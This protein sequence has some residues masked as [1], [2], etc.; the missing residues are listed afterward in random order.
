MVPRVRRRQEQRV[1]AEALAGA[2]AIETT[3]ADTLDPRTISEWWHRAVGRPLDRS[4][5]A[6]DGLRHA[7]HLA[8]DLLD[9]A[10][11]NQG[12]SRAV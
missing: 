2:G 9:A 1:R 4:R 8:A 10:Y 7:A 5:I 6:R 3:P 12:A 11:A